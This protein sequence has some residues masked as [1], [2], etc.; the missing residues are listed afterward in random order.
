MFGAS[1]L[2]LV[3]VI[4]VTNHWLI[5]CFSFP[6]SIQ[7]KT[8]SR[9]VY[10][11]LFDRET[12]PWFLVTTWAKFLQSQRKELL[13]VCT[14]CL[15]WANLSFGDWTCCY[16][17]FKNW[18]SRL[19]WELTSLLVGLILVALQFGW[20]EA[21]LSWPRLVQRFNQFSLFI[22]HSDFKALVIRALT[23]L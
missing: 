7:T 18:A 1:S 14:K 5:F 23:L 17:C 11:I 4:L 15:F 16:Q 3:I 21:E 6:Q 2:L 12:N 20:L 22:C 13:E 8:S 19:N 9:F 10:S